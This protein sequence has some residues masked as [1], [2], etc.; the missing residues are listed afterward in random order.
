MMMHNGITEFYNTNKDAVV[1]L[2]SPRKYVNDYSTVA[3]SIYNSGLVN[4]GNPTL[5]KSDMC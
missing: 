3:G 5:L 1:S 4:D 2:I